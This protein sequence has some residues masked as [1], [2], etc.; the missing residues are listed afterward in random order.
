ML[1]GRELLQEGLKFSAGDSVAQ[2]AYDDEFRMAARNGAE[3]PDR[4]VARMHLERE[5]AEA[6][7]ALGFD[8]SQ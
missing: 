3:I 4:I 2:Q 8:E 5:A 1:R 7:I 6:Q